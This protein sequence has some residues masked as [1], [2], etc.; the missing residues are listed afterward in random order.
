MLLF[1]LYG[2][3]LFCIDEFPVSLLFLIVCPVLKGVLF[4][5]SSQLFVLLIQSAA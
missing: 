1:S 3:S 2:F 4:V 5:F